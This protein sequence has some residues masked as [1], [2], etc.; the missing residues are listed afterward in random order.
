[1]TTPTEPVTISPDCAARI[2][3]G[4]WREERVLRRCAFPLAPRNTWSNVAYIVAGAWV[5][6]FRTTLNDIAMAL[7]LILL[8]CGSAAYH[9]WKTIPT[10]RLD[11][12]GMYAVFGALAIHGIVPEVTWAALPMALIGAGLAWRWAWAWKGMGLEEQMGLLLVVASLRPLILGPRG[13]ILAGWALFVLAMGAWQLDR[14]T[15]RLGLWGHAIW[16]ILTAAA[17]TLLYWG[18]G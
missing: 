17:I 12:A 4:G 3:R 13:L 5:L 14:R 8:G 7:A 16:H 10:H 18:Q 15:T 1:M 9:G 11:L 6:L 2:Y